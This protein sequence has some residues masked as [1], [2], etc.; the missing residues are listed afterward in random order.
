MFPGFEKI[1]ESRIKKAQDEGAFEDLPG[2]GQPLQL[3]NDPHIPEDLRLAH[4]VL[5]NADCLPP[6][7][8]LRKEIRTTEELL[9][10]MTDTVKKHRTIKKLNYLIMKLNATRGASA[11]FDIPQR[12]YVDVVE[13][14]ESDNA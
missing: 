9:S 11:E 8:Q 5:K 3:E 4:K 12:Y 13:R 6:E 10:G 14:I 7:V 1:I 2:S